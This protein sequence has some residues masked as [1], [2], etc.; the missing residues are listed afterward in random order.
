MQKYIPV[1]VIK[2]LGE[3]DKILTAL[4]ISKGDENGNFNA[5]KNGTKA[6]AVVLINRS[7][8]VMQEIVA[9]YES[10]QSAQEEYIESL[11]K[12]LEETNKTY[13]DI[14]TGHPVVK[15]TMQN[16]K[17]FEITLY[18]EYAPETCANFLYLVKEGF[19]D[20]LTFHRVIDGF[21][22]Q[23]G[24]PEGDGT[25]GA[26]NTIYGEF[27]SNGFDKNTL[28]HEAGVVSMARNQLENSASSQFF[29]CFDNATHLDGQYAAFGKVTKGMNVVLDFAK[30]ETT[31]SI[32][33]E[34]SLPVEPIVIK[35]ATVIKSK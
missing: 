22:A 7:Y 27:L 8:G 26:E 28:K 19:Y 15:F 16:G 6:E 9:Y 31:T 35:K 2:E 18:P 21:M 4:N 5:D 13:T 23:G 24:D 3:T 33:G 29:I 25:G 17:S 1:V 10:L 12:Q 32:S 34:L 14:P 30:V 11:K 20:G